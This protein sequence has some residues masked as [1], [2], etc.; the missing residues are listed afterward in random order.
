[1]CDWDHLNGWISSAIEDLPCFNDLDCCHFSQSSLLSLNS[2]VV[3]TNLDWTEMG[4]IGK[5]Y[6]AVALCVA[7]GFGLG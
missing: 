7:V 3:S 4:V 1:M 6:T 2:S 5:I